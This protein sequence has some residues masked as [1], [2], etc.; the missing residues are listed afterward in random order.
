MY[1]ILPVTVKNMFEYSLQITWLSHIRE[2]G[3]ESCSSRLERDTLSEGA[4]GR[5][6]WS[7]ESC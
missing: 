7:V 4:R 3:E 5:V 2:V 6:K 1:S